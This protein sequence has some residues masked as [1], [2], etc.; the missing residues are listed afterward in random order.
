MSLKNKQMKFSSLRKKLVIKLGFT[1]L[2]ALL[3]IILLIIVKNTLDFNE[4]IAD[5]QSRTKASLVNKGML[6]VENNSDALI[7][8]VDDNAFTAV[9][10]IVTKTVVSD[11]DIVYGVFS[12]SDHNDWVNSIEHEDVAVIKLAVDANARWAFEQI[13]AAS[14]LINIDKVQVIEFAAPVILDGKILGVIRYGLSTIVLTEAITTANKKATQSLV[15]TLFALI[16]VGIITLIIT[17][18]R[19][20]KLARR[21]T[22]P[23]NLLTEAADI[24]ARGQYDHV[25]KIETNDEIGMLANNFN[26]MTNAINQTIADLAEINQ[27]GEELAKTHN[28]LQAFKWVLKGILKQ[29]PFELALVFHTN[30][31]AQFKLLTH[32]SSSNQKQQGDISSLLNIIDHHQGINTAIDNGMQE[33]E[34]I[35]FQLPEISDESDYCSL[36]LIPFGQKNSKALHLIL[37]TKHHLKNLKQSEVDFCLSISHLLTTSLQNIS[38]NGLLEEQNKTLED[39]VRERT[40]ELNIQNQ[41]LTKTLIE[42]E[43]AQN[44]LIESEKMASLGCLVAGISHEVNT[45][46]GVSVT[47]ASV[48]YEQT[49]LFNNKF[50]NGKLTKS[51]FTSYL[52]DASEATSIILTNLERASTLIQS[53]KQ[54][55]VDQSSDVQVDFY[56]KQ[57]LDKLITS[58][59]PS[60]KT[61]PIKINLLGDDETQ[62]TSYPGS[63][64][65]V[66]TNLIVNSIKHGLSDCVQGEINIIVNLANEQLSIIVEDT[67]CGI[68]DDIKNKVFDP[69]FTTKRGSG[70]TGLGLNI[71]YNIVKQK[72]KGEI[73]LENNQPQG[74]RFI[75]KFPAH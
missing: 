56:V 62:I 66:V 5:I 11:D 61:L 1:Y 25:I 16:L 14:K 13:K 22:V 59:R 73:S 71:V 2:L 4:S 70:G 75:I 36:V 35:T 68:P 40:N 29:L 19:T 8:L 12:D 58:L 37:C 7:G 51:G 21:I 64:N 52:S 31:N 23:L 74:T 38:M 34:F 3:F 18:W 20:D 43:K 60:Y 26:S 53:F 42:L 72:L 57:H 30:L 9:E 69:F 48:L 17:F 6:L 32:Y 28:E 54:I 10:Q 46:L 41:A 67:G 65:Q 39:K 33:Q 63:L 47:A 15:Q 45:P 49:E 50:K 24:V 27:V 55:A 44:H